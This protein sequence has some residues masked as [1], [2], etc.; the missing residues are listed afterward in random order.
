MSQVCAL[1]SKR[2]SGPIEFYLCKA[3]FRRMGR[4]IMVKC[5]CRESE[6][7]S[8]DSIGRLNLKDYLTFLNTLSTTGDNVRVP[9]CIED[10]AGF[11]FCCSNST[12][13]YIA[14]CGEMRLCEDC[15]KL[16]TEVR[17]KSPQ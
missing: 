17:V 14:K 5:D 1:Q 16:H 11:L 12:G 10:S 3:H 6:A 15:I 7:I 13:D 4:T 8:G 2:C 9:D